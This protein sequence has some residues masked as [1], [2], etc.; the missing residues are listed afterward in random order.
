MFHENR[1]FDNYMFDE[2]KKIRNNFFELQPK[3]LII[4]TAN[5]I[6]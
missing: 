1:K 3:F 4:P 5:M 6:T 2:S